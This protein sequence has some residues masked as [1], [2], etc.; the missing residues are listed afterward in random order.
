MEAPMQTRLIARD[1]EWTFGDRDRAG[2]LLEELLGGLRE[3]L[4]RPLPFFAQTSYAYFNSLQKIREYEK[5]GKGRKPQPLWKA[6]YGQWQGDQ[7]HGGAAPGERDDP[8]IALCFRDSDPLVDLKEAFEE[9][10]EWFWG[11]ALGSRV[12]P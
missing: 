8:Y 1:D 5:T 11:Y 4:Q 2:E 9:R 10:A 6:A 3:A 7:F 12:N